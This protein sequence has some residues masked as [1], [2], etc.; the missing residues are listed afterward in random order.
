MEG[1]GEKN[2][3]GSGGNEM[4]GIDRYLQSVPKTDTDKPF[5]ESSHKITITR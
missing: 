5:F 3:Q 2:F 4:D 1:S